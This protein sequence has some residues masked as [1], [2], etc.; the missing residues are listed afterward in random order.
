MQTANCRSDTRLLPCAIVLL[1]SLGCGHNARMSVEGTA[2][3]DGRPLEKGYIRFSP[4]PGT[5]GPT[6][7][8]E[9]V[10]GKFVVLSSG[11]PFAGDFTVQITAAGLTGRKVLDPRSN[12]MV[13]EYAQYLPARYN[14]QSELRAKVT[15]GGSNRF[16]F[17]LTTEKTSSAPK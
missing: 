11:G 13:D 14:S 15:A 8:A 17:A 16:D 6:A 4:L 5:T 2:T 7:G 12:A 10:N 1:A 3:L 9:I